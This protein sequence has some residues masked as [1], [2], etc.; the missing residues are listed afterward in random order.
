MTAETS[1]DAHVDAVLDRLERIDDLDL[2]AQLGAFAE[3]QEQL[4]AVLDADVAVA[5]VD[6]SGTAPVLT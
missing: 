2:P 4:A 3:A 5:D 6:S 1:G